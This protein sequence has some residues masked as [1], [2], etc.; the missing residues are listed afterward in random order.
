[1]LTVPGRSA[2]ALLNACAALDAA[3]HWPAAAAEE[4]ASS[5]LLSRLASVLESRP[6]PPPHATRKA[7]AKPSPA[8]KNARVPR[9]IRDLTLEAEPVT[10]RLG[11][12]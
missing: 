7:A 10:F 2:T 11:G 8:A 9:P 1:M 4:T 6:A 5:W 3:P 12:N